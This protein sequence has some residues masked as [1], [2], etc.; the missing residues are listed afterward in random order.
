M[1]IL[2]IDP[3]THIIGYGLLDYAPNQYSSPTFGTLQVPPK[4]P[5]PEA[6]NSIYSDLQELLQWLEPEV[7]VIE[8]LFFFRN[9]STAMSVAQARG[10]MVLATAQAGLPQAE[11]TPLQVKMTLTGYGRASKQ[12]VQET[13]RDLLKLEQVP[14]PDDAA[15]ALALAI[16]HAHYLLP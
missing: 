2:G 6:L 7:V 16:T 10:V 3:G 4:T 9:V 15:D 1:R 8:Q 12:E 11:Y 13:V 5:L 14:K